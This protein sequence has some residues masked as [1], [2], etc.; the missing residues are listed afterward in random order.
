MALPVRNFQPGPAPLH[1]AHR[2]SATGVSRSGVRAIEYRNMSLPTRLP[3]RRWIAA[4]LCVT[5]CDSAAALLDTKVR[6][7]RLSRTRSS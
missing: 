7:T 2:W 5:F 3:K 1:V 4:R 6:T